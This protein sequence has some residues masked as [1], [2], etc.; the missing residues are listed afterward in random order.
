LL[1]AV[2]ESTKL[3]AKPR[4]LLGVAKDIPAAEMRRLLLDSYVVSEEGVRQLALERGVVIRDALIAKG[5]PN[6][7]LFLGAPRLVQTQATSA[8]ASAASAAPPELATGAS[9]MP[10]AEL[11]LSSH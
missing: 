11:K 7:R 8:S 2:Y 6:G 10:Y 4:N 1:K 3:P 9:W 5:L